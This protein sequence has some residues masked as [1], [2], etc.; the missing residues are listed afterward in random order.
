MQGYFRDD[1]PLYELIL[2]EQRAAR[3]RRAVARARL[4]H[5]WPRMR[6]Y[7]DFIFFERAEPPRF[8]REA[9]FDFARSEDK[10]ADVR[11]EDRRGW[12]KLYLAKA[13]RSG[14]SDE[15][16]EAI[17]TYFTDISARDPPGRA[18]AGWPP[19]RAT[20]RRSRSSPSGPTAGRCRRPSATS[21]L[22]FY[23][24]LR[25]QDG[26]GHE[27]AMRD[28]LVSVLMSPHFCYRVDLAAAGR[29]ARSRCRTTRWPA[30]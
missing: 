26:L 17:E 20:S 2:D 25:E 14:A 30:G 16:L 10:D 23:R 9:E 18:A 12:P 5:R 28:T 8:M 15:A 4:H 29:R 21:S 3:A 19:S 22:A 7:K 13:Q 6:Q 1:E 27:D 24:T 11:G